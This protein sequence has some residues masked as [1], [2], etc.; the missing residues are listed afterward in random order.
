MFHPNLVQMKQKN[1]D[2]EE[3]RESIK[4]YQIIYEVPKKILFKSPTAKEYTFENGPNELKEAIIIGENEHS[5]LTR[6]VS[7]GV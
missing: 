2:T 7:E 5:Y 1:I 4:K 3:T 6:E